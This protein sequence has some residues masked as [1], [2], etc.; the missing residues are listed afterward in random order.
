MASS[1]S[2]MLRS[3]PGRSTPKAAA[4][5]AAPTVNFTPA[6]IPAA[7]SVSVQ[8]PATLPRQNFLRDLLDPGK[9]TYIGNKYR[10]EL[11][12]AG[13]DLRTGLEGYGDYEFTDDAA[14]GATTA[15][16]KEGGQPGRLYREGY[17]DARSQTAAAGMLYSRT[18][19][20][21]IGTAWHRLGEQE[22]AVFNQYA[23]QASEITGRMAQEF[24]GITNELYGLYGEDIRYALENPQPVQAPAAAAPAGEPPAPAGAASAGGNRSGNIVTSMRRGDLS[25]GILSSLAQS[26]PGYKVVI[27]GNGKVVLKKVA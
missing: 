2:D 11:Q 19:D 1:Y 4:A 21:A 15:K 17:Q 13:R 3:L 27:A 7:P 9:A 8:N 25:P 23:G 26:H 24:T 22:R 5:P 10:T 12:V 18:A 14:T 20:Q 16:K 6:P